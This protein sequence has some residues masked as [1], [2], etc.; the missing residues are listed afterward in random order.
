MLSSPSTNLYKE[1]LER[2]KGEEEAKNS[3]SAKIVEL[4]GRL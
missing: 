4:E 1:G 2:E 3:Y